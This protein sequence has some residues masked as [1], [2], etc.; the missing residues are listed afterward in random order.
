MSRKI[1]FLFY[2]G[3]MFLSTVLLSKA[4]Q[5]LDQKGHPLMSSLTCI[6]TADLSDLYWNINRIELSGSI[7][8]EDKSLL[9]TLRNSIPHFD[10]YFFRIDG[11]EG[12]QKSADGRIVLETK[13]GAHTIE[14]KA[15]TTMG[16]EL[17]SIVRTIKVSDN[18]VS[19][20]P[21]DDNSA[22][23]RYGFR[24]EKTGSAKI[25]WLREHT[26]PV[27]AA[28]PNQWHVFLTLRSWVNKQIPN[29][30]PVMKSHWDAQ[31]ILQAVWSDPS[32]G[33]ICD[34]YAATF[35][36]ACISAGLNAR[37]VHLGDQNYNGHYAAEIWSDDHNKWI[38]MDPLYDRHFSL[39]DRP[40][41]A[42]ELHNVWKQGRME[43]IATHGRG[44]AVVNAA[45]LSR[46]YTKLFQDIQLVNSNDFLTTPFTSVM[47]IFTMKIRFLR[48]IDESNPPYNRIKLAGQLLTFYYLPILIAGVIIPFVIPAFLIFMTIRLGKR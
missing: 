1:K 30:Y 46:D 29:R 26:A 44:G 11:K 37:M 43:E 23:G 14:L 45:T 32:L 18:S 2:L 35:V 4:A 38:F 39:P 42:V 19:V 7:S 21:G 33:F 17:P 41:S 16:G 22:G 25:A 24:F 15:S 48:Y 28:C 10:S 34:A 20:F 6:E 31:R 36:S 3:I 47:D 5:L 12:W 40:L 27:I 13:E 8:K 9:L